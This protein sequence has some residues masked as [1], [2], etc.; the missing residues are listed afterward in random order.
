MKIKIISVACL[1]ILCGCGLAGSKGVPKEQLNADIGS[2]AL[3]AADGKS[4]NFPGD[5]ERCF[6][7]M[8]DQTKI[9]AANA[10][11]MVSVG[12]WRDI[13]IGNSN[14]YNTV[15]GKLHLQ[16]KMDGGK[17][18]LEK[19][20]PVELINKTLETEDFKK[21]VDI[22]MPLCKYYRFTDYGK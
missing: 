22:Q 14:L 5:T 20:E 13:S 19:I 3:T 18:V 12:S 11:I 10:D 4:W 2:K 21:F 7:V 16:Y 1:L 17:W 8:D 6:A 9:T 15:Y